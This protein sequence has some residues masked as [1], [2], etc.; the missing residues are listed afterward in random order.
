MPPLDPDLASVVPGVQL[1]PPGV[2]LAV[3]DV[4]T[5][6]VEAGRHVI[7]APLLPPD[8][9]M[10][11]VFLLGTVL[12]IL[13]FQRGLVPLHASAVDIHGR[14]LLISGVSGAGKSTLATAFSMSGYRLLSDDLCALQ[15]IEGQPLRILSAFPRVRLWEDSARQLGVPTDD[16]E[17]SREGLEKYNLPLQEALFQPE[18]LPPAPIVFLKTDRDAGRPPMR[19]LVGVEAMRRYDLVHRW[20]LGAALGYQAL[21]FNAMARL[22]DAVPMVEVARSEH[23]SDLPALVDRVR[24]LGEVPVI[25]CPAR[26]SE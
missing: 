10:I 20:Q 23:L 21:I 18:A 24:A 4:A 15:L 3:P 14:A 17:R 8:A 7:I 2:R 25:D 6:W 16:L 12:A 19:R 13:C 11:R 1:T 5:Y 22:A 26:S 9:P